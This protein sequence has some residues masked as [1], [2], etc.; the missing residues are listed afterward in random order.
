LGRHSSDESHVLVGGSQRFIDDFEA[1]LGRSQDDMIAAWLEEWAG[2]QD[3]DPDGGL[4]IGDW[5]PA[6]LAHV[7]GPERAEA[8]L[9]ASRLRRWDPPAQ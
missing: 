7:V 9:S 1:G 4:H 3:R 2:H 6:Q 8:A 5:I